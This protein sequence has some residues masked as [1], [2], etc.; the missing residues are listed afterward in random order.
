MISDLLGSSLALLGDGCSTA[1]RSR[2]RDG[3]F[4]ELVTKGSRSDLSHDG[5][6]CDSELHLDVIGR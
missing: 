5:N 4:R 3:R 2:S 1:S 6:E